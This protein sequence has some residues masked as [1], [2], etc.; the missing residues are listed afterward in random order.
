MP[1]LIPRLTL[2]VFLGIEYPLP[3]SIYLSLEL[4]CT[5]EGWWKS[6]FVWVTESMEVTQSLA[7]SWSGIYSPASS[8]ALSPPSIHSPSIVSLRQ[9]QWSSPLLFFVAEGAIK[10][11]L[12]SCSHLRSL[13]TTACF[14]C[15]L[16][17]LVMVAI[18]KVPHK[19]PYA[20]DSVTSLQHSWKVAE[21]LG[22]GA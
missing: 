16:V 10:K 12:S 14:G 20:K 18:L 8:L 17:G 4:C 19:V 1:A 7:W 22:S 6:S 9:R 15:R 21:P 2:Q 5:L 11:G 3:V 13:P